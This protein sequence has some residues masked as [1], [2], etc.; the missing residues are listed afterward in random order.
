M[1]KKSTFGIWGNTDKKL[2]WKVLPKILS[3]SEKKQLEPFLT[4]RILQHP[5]IGNM[6][7]KLIETKE[8]FNH[9]RINDNKKP[10]STKKLK[11]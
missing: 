8:Q 2:F 3:W 7:A 5:N 11:S 6:N 10:T 4:S 9:L 1:N